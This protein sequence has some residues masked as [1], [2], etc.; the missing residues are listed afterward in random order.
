MQNF[1]FIFIFFKINLKNHYKGIRMF[2]VENK[3]R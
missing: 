2:H 1:D 3:E